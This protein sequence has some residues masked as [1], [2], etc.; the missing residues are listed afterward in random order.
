MKKVIAVALMLFSSLAVAEDHFAGYVFNVVE[1]SEYE[2]G[3]ALF[4]QIAG[5][6]LKDP[7]SAKIQGKM[8]AAL[9][10]EKGELEIC[11]MMNSKNGFGA[12]GGAN[13]TWVR[14]SDSEGNS[15]EIGRNGTRFINSRC[16]E[17]T[18][19][20]GKFFEKNKK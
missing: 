10:R 13:L 9:N 17:M 20:A 14:I 4:L 7:D 3:A 2:K 15:A 16:T 8:L 18:E 19:A 6:Q 5:A 12:Y 11:A 1:P